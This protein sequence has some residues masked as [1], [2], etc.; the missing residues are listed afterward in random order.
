MTIFY[1]EA[2]ADT[3]IL[4]NW[5]IAQ[6]DRSSAIISGIHEFHEGQRVVSAELLVVDPHLRWCLTLHGGYRL[7]TRGT[8]ARDFSEWPRLRSEGH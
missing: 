5:T 6:G 4:V 8:P 2:F 1:D 3:P 7:L